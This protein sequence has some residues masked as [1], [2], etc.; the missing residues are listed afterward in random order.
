[1]ITVLGATGQVG[2][3]V[4]AKLLA[5]KQRVRVIGRDAGKLAQMHQGAEAAAGDINDVAFLTKTL[6]GVDAAFVMIPPDYSAKSF[7]EHYRKASEAIV[8]AI[9]ASGIKHVVD[10]SS[11]GADLE[12]GTGP[13]KF[14]HAHEERLN[15][16]EGVNV[17]HLRPAYFFENLL[18]NTELIK[19]QSIMGSHI[20]ADVKMAM[21]AT[22]DIAA[23]AVDALTTRAFKGKSVQELLGPKDM[24]MNE[25]AAHISEAAGKP[26][27]YIAFDA[28]ST[29]QALLGFGFSLDTANLFVEMSQ[30]LNTGLIR[31]KRNAASTTTTSFA[32]FANVFRG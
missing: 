20:A 18:A 4:A 29:K 28:D 17:L 22:D 6:T 10:L 21:I 2:S 14:L 11:F 12:D 23:A 31:P 15:K 13:I 19:A 5:Q 9:K 26:V 7:G 16:I 8:Q 30:A 25:A 32:K 27:K 1:M 24:T 3:K